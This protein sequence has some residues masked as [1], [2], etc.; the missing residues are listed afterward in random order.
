MNS[1]SSAISEKIQAAFEANG[2]RQTTAKIQIA[3]RLAKLGADEGDFTVE[4]LWHELRRSNP[5]LGRATVFRAV[6]MLVNQGLLNRIDFPDGSHNYRVCGD[7][8]H[9]HITCVQC[10]RV[11]DI[12]F[13]PPLK[14]LDSVARQADFEIEGHSLTLF[15]LC[16]DCRKRKTNTK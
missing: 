13:C 10:H 5:H 4:K 7:S 1:K 2:Q 12:D 11:V 16:A 8:H 14:Q 15:G 6:E 3:E 9:H